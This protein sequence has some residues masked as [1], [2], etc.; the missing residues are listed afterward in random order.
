MRWLYRGFLRSSIR[1][2][3]STSAGLVIFELMRRKYAT[4]ADTVLIEKDGFDILLT[5]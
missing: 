3:P 2:V 4:A 1:Q 5:N